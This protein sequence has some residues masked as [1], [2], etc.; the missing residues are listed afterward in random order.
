MATKMAETLKQPCC[1]RIYGDLF[2]GRNCANPATVE[3]DG[4]WNC[5]THDPVMVKE[6]AAE[7]EKLW[8]EKAKAQEKSRAIQRDTIRV[9]RFRDA[10]EDLKALSP[11]GGDRRTRLK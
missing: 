8:E 2:Y 1:K 6:R 5:N 7:R 10:P 4:K 9:W 11:H 3:R